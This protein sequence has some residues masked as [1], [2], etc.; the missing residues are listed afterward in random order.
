MPN[1]T[2]NTEAVKTAISGLKDIE[3]NLSEIQTKLYSS[4]IALNATWTGNG[5]ASFLLASTYARKNI[6]RIMSSV[7]GIYDVTIKACED[8]V[9]LDQNVS[10]AAT[11]KK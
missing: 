3:A 1:S 8:R 10:T 11:I 7:S 6:N 9:L 5:K 2:I 4:G